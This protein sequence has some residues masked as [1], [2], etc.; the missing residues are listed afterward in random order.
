[1]AGVMDEASRGAH[2][3]GGLVVGVLPDSDDGHMSRHVDIA[4]KTDMGSARNNINVLSS[5][6]VVACGLG[7]GTASEVSLALKA[8]KP[9]VLV[10]V[11]QEDFEFFSRLSPKLVR[12]ANSATEAIS[13]VKELLL[14]LNR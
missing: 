7:A 6:V 4:I 12:H 9:V 14:K 2:D 10:S 13:I 5:D 11:P 3:A 8:D 1:M